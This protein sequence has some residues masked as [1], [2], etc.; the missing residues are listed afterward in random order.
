[1]SPLD[2]WYSNRYTFPKIYEVIKCLLSAPAIS[3]A[4]ERCFST[5]GRLINDKRSTIGSNIVDD[6]VSVK[7]NAGKIPDLKEYFKYKLSY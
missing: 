2:F 4:S 5:L 1:M 7:F 6:I 3:C